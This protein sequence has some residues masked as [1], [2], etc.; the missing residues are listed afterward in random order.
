MLTFIIENYSL[1]LR[2]RL[3]VFLNIQNETKNLRSSVGSVF[4]VYYKLLTTHT[5]VVRSQLPYLDEEPK[6]STWSHLRHSGVFDNWHRFPGAQPQQ[7]YPCTPRSPGKCSVRASPA[8][9]STRLTHTRVATHSQTLW[10]VWSNAQAR[11]NGDRV[12]KYTALKNQNSQHQCRWASYK[13]CVQLSGLMHC[14][15]CF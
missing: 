13:L 3:P 5:P 8:L 4:W 10:D 1:D 12:L 7:N 14:I 9:V 11:S 15:A 2:Q 6:V